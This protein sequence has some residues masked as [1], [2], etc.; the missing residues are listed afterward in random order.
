VCGCGDDGSSPDPVCRWKTAYEDLFDSTTLSS[1]WSLFEGDTSVYSLTGDA[2]AVNDSD[3]YEDGPV[4]IYADTLH[5]D[6]TRVTCRLRTEEM[7]G[8]VEMGVVMRA[9]ETASQ[10]YA[11]GM[12]DGLRLIEGGSGG[13]TEMAHD[14]SFEMGAEQTIVVICEVNGGMLSM[15]AET[16][17]GGQLGKV[18]ATDPTPLPPGFAGFFGEIDGTDEEYLYF[19]SIKLEEC[20]WD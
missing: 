16:P 18:T 1:S 3:E 14:P 13:D 17:S 10:Y 5:A 11:F 8:E 7:N 9:T 19:D 6:R 4:L 15:T 2:L 20:E 12:W